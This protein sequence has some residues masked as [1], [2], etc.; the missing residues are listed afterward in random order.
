MAPKGEGLCVSRNAEEDDSSAEV[1]RQT[2][3]RINPYTESC[4]F[5]A[6][7]ARARCCS[8]EENL[9]QRVEPHLTKT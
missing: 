4:L 6:L 9:K 2:L 3:S 7:C 5:H 1:F 8:S